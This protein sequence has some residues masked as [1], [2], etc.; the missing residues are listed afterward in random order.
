MSEERPGRVRA[1]ATKKT[2]IRR[3]A[4]RGCGGV[5]FCFLV[6]MAAA[7]GTGLGTFVWIVDDAKTTIAALDRFRPKTGSKVYSADE[8]L[9]GEYTREWRQLVPLN[10]IPLHLQKAFVATEDHRFYVHK[11]VRPA[12]ILSA[13]LYIVRTG[14]IRGGSTITQQVVRN[15]EDLDVGTERALKRKI[16]EATVALQ[17][18]RQFTK[19]EILELYL[20]K[21][22]LGGGA[23]GVETAALQYF[24]KSCRDLTLGESALLAG[25]ARA[26]NRQRP[27]FHP[28]NALS[29][30][31]IVLDQMIECGMITPEQRDAALAESLEDMLVTDEKRRRMEE[32]ARGPL[33][34]DE[35]NAPYFVEEVRRRVRGARHVSEDQLRESGLEIHT[36]VDMRL[37]R[38]AERI[39]KAHLE[40]FDEDKL[41]YLKNRNRESEFVP[42]TGALV[43]IDN[44]PL[45]EGYVRALVGGRDWATQ[46]FNNATQAKR[47]PG[48]SV[49]PFVW[50]AALGTGR[51]SGFT[52]SH[53]EVDAPLTRY[54]DLGRPWTPRNFGNEYAG[55][56][57]LRRAL[58][59][60]INIVSVKLVEQVGMP[61][62]R[63]YL[64]VAGI[65]TPIDNSHKMTI[66]LGTPEVLVLDQ[67]VAYSTFAKGGVYSPPVFLTEIRDRDGLKQYR[68]RIER[69]QVIDADLAYVMTYLLQGV[70]TRGTGA[71]SKALNRPRA[72]KTGT[73]NENRNVWFCGF[74]PQYTCVVWVG[75][76]DNRPLGIGRNFTGGKIACPIWTEFMIEAHK[77]LPVLE[78]NPPDDVVFFPVDRETGVLAS[79]VENHGEVIREAFLAGT[80]P[81]VTVPA[82]LESQE[83]ERE[84]MEM[85]F[86]EDL[87]L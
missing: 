59:K 53:M 26:P 32:G 62:V 28:E 73:T 76:Q 84:L 38:S 2:P 51:Q 33:G 25:L 30:R 16:I 31:S 46:K 40:Q 12:A 20:N 42:V 3:K 35:F 37:Q 10:E 65:T 66:A 71:R 4:A 85:Q 69:T 63:R 56:V 82:F 6:L 75:Y 34:P 9:L 14:N 67:C 55:P 83:L 45:S 86:L 74:T 49:K 39:L 54:D 58:E 36:T 41:E 81:P 57:T 68:D 1:S 11:G 21:I 13:A 22:F 47:Q 72:G 44:R 87:R 7:W 19:D 23:Q 50:A 79:E 61:L 78:F 8:Q 70:A 43:C 80:A 17:V 15:V 24:G 64:Q 29:R 52:A 5:F 18:E 77:G 60:S 48:S 27:D